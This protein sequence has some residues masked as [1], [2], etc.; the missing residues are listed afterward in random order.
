MDGYEDPTERENLLISGNLINELK[1]G[2]TKHTLLIGT[3]MI[4]TENSNLRHD[5]YWSTTQT[6]RESF[7]ITR[8]MDF[9]VNVDGVATSVDFATNLKSKTESDIE[10]TSFYVQDQID[11]N[12]S[13]H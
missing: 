3:E 1:F 6:D 4:D 13:F 8:P 12:E 2:S 9:S 7:F 11:V 10:V 5:T